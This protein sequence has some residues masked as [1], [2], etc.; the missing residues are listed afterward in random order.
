MRCFPELGAD[1][2]AF[3]R[4]L[5]LPYTVSGGK[6]L[7][8]AMA[9]L[10]SFYCSILPARELVSTQATEEAASGVA[11]PE[12][13]REYAR[14]YNSQ[15]PDL[16]ICGFDWQ[17]YSYMADGEITGILIELLDLAK[18]PA[19]L[20]F[21][22]MPLPRCV[23]AVRQGQ[24]HLIPYLA[25]HYPSILTVD[26]AVQYH[27]AG[28]IVSTKS[29]HQ[30]FENLA[31]FR[32]DTIGVLRGNPLFRS[33][34]NYQGIRWEQQNSGKSMWQM[35]MRERLD[36]AVGDFVSLTPLAVYRTGEVRFLR[37]ALYVLPIRMGLN[38]EQAALLPQLQQALSRLL[39]DGSVDRLYRKHSAQR[40]SEIQQMADDYLR[41]Q[42]ERHN[43]AGLP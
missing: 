18:L 3:S 7:A 26:T 36:G 37:P 39:A 24:Q 43:S 9:L 8:V 40:F 10:A 35:L 2:Y 31:Q 15:L 4:V 30:T 32:G 5:N 38:S 21:S 12:L 16:K 20:K 29:Q 42:R 11:A 23:A 1:I 41:R 22:L 25:S 28:M 27:V 14:A 13:G 34:S 19:N 17:P 33:L 6:I